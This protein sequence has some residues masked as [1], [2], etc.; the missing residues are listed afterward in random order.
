MPRRESARAGRR[1]TSGSGFHMPQIGPRVRVHRRFAFSGEVSSRSHCGCSRLRR[2]RSVAASVAS[3]SSRTRPCRGCMPSVL[4]ARAIRVGL[5][6]PAQ[7][8]GQLLL[9][10]LGAG[11]A[12]AGQARHTRRCSRRAGVGAGGSREPDRVS[13][14][15]TI[16]GG[17]GRPW[18]LAV[19]GSAEARGLGTRRGSQ[20][21]TRVALRPVRIGQDV[22]RTAHPRIEW[23]QG[24]LHRAQLWSAPARPEPTP[25]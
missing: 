1:T 22:P 17:G 21:G 12:R 7:H 9:S 25:K 5:P 16:R 6:R 24:F 20:V 3:S 14:C 2:T 4:C 10:S 18:P 8:A 19:E 23:P 15:D 11:R 13:R